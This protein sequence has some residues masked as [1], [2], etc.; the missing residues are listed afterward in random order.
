MELR[1]DLLTHG[2]YVITAKFEDQMSGLAVAWASQAG[3]DRFMFCVGSQSLTR[4]L[5]LK[6]AHFGLHVLEQSQHEL[7]RH[8]GRKTGKNVDKFKGLTYEIGKYGSPMLGVCAA[9]YEC[10][11]EQ[12]FDLDDQKIIVG[13]ILTAQQFLEQ[14]K[15]L[16][17][18]E[19]DY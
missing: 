7:A 13:K 6:S 19:D 15:P 18:S 10:A 3:K 14:Y 16:I 17:Y 5:I 4:E 8:F 2:V 11:V 9:R 1:H 12:V